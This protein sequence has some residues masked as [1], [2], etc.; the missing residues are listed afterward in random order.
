[1]NTSDTA[2][3]GRKAAF[4]FIFASAL[5]NAVSFGVTIPVLPALIKEFAGGDTASA[6]EWQMMFGAVWGLMQFVF[7][8]ILGVLSDRIGR[9]PV[10]LISFLGLAFDFL[11]LVFAPSLMWLFVARIVNGMTAASFST[12]NAY[13][14]DVTPPEQRARYFGFMGASFGFGFLIG[15]VLGGLLAGPFMESL[16]GD[17]AIRLPFAVA[18]ALALLNFLYGL[19]VLPESLPPEKRSARFDWRRANPVGSLQFLREQGRLVGLATVGFL[20]QI[21]HNVLPAIF[22]LYTG[23][24]YGWDIQ[25]ISLTMFLTGGLGILMQTLAVG[26]IVRRLGERGA[27]LIGCAGA[28]LGFLAYGLAPTGI[29]YLAAAPVF[30]LSNL[31]APG[32]Q[33]LMSRRVGPEVQGRLQGANQSLSGIAT[34]IGPFLFGGSFAYALR[35]PALSAWPGLPILIASALMFIAL[36]VAWRYGRNDAPSPAAGPPP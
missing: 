16:V 3:A 34:I 2:P 27:L 9:R 12:A 6:A 20:F 23:H 4:G 10:L 33:G 7:G 15:P 36:G 1:M 32:L 11:F 21:A 14:A 22:V 35:H 8:P 30:A 24:R 18:G 28:A 5:L 31:L 13:V 26:P 29:A 17:F 25:T 19:F